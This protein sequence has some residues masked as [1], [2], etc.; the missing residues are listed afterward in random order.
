VELEMTESL[1]LQ[2]AEENIPV[3]NELGRHHIRIAV[4]DF[5]TGYS[6]L[7]YLTQLPIDT[8]K[9][10]RSFTRNLPHDRD[11][12]AIVRAIVAMGHNLGLRVTAEGVETQE[13]LAV[14]RKMRCD[15]FQ[16][17][18]FSKPVPAPELIELLRG[19]TIPVRM[20]RKSA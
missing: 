13:Q 6:S 1:L 11:G 12:L 4:D 7:S 2:N 20:R 14:L 19:Q 9:I 16:G 10:D 3:L 15:E 5:G 8:L 17:Y 18:L